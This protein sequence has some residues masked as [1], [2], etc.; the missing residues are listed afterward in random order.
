MVVV[1]GTLVVVVGTP[2]VVGGTPVVVVGGTLV[3]VGGALVVVGVT[4]VIVV[5]VVDT[6]TVELIEGGSGLIIMDELDVTLIMD[7]VGESVAIEVK[8]EEE[9]EALSTVEDG[10][11]VTVSVT[12]G[13]KLVE[14]NGMLVPVTVTMGSM[15]E[16]DPTKSIVEVRPNISVSED[17]SSDVGSS[18]TDVVVDD[19]VEESDIAEVMV[20]EGTEELSS[21]LEGSIEEV[22]VILVLSSVLEGS[23]EEVA[24]ILVLSSVLEGS[25][26]EV[27]VILVLSSVLEG[28]IKVI[29]SVSISLEV[30][31]I[32]STVS[33]VDSDDSTID[34]I[35]IF[36]E[37]ELE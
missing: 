33:E 6:R 15:L 3:V 21:V 24:M 17:K 16:E 19:I 22:A 5:V 23:I 32:F 4:L 20:E 9:N 8:M 34:D 36:A 29:V 10:V 18:I 26:E 30:E 35:V 12:L 13:L 37:G 25:I 1:G 27:A 11:I 31:M 14:I 28:A 2:V 7:G